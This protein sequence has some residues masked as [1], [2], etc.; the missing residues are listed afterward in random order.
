MK[1]L[2]MQFPPIIAV[3]SENHMKVIHPSALKMQSF[4]ILKRVV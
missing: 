3:Y 4:R 2:I 1:L